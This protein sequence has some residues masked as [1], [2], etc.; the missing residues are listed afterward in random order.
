[1]APSNF[2]VTGSLYSGCRASPDLMFIDLPDSIAS[3]LSAPAPLPVLRDAGAVAAEAVPSEQSSFRLPPAGAWRPASSYFDD[4]FLNSSS[5]G[6]MVPGK[7]SRDSGPNMRTAAGPGCVLDPGPQSMSTAADREYLKQQ[8]Q[9]PAPLATVGTMRQVAKGL[10]QGAHSEDDADDV[11]PGGADDGAS[12]PAYTELGALHIPNAMQ[13]ATGWQQHQQQVPFYGGADQHAPFFAGPA[14]SHIAPAAQPVLAVG[15]QMHNPAEDAAAVGAAALLTGSPAAL[16]K[17]LND[18]LL[19]KGIHRRQLLPV[20]EGLQSAGFIKQ[21]KRS[22]LGLRRGWSPKAAG[23]WVLRG[24]EHLTLESPEVKSAVEY[25]HSSEPR[26]IEEQQNGL[27]CVRVIVSAKSGLG[28]AQKDEAAAE[29]QL[30]EK[31]DLYAV[32]LLMW[33]LQHVEGLPLGVLE[34]MRE[35]AENG[36]LDTASQQQARSSVRVALGG[37]CGH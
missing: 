27:G 24:H 22:L 8:Q 12:L 26:F 35:A 16:I 9:Q 36:V 32:A 31:L 25:T 20:L 5:V 1:M 13:A 23:C 17:Q 14:A 19:L 2:Q 34:G 11:L 7:R 21:L 33:R 3:D 37:F 29:Q 6:S 4:S 30:F 15:V 18:Y 28:R 10:F